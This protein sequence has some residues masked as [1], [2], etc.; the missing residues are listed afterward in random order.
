MELDRDGF[1]E[2]QLEEK[3]KKKLGELL[4]VPYDSVDMNQPMTNY[5]VDSMMSMELATWASR[6]LCLNVTQLEVLSGLTAAS[7]LKKAA[8]GLQ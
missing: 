5:G 2:E 6:E 1:S 7:L 3:I 4:H 8:V